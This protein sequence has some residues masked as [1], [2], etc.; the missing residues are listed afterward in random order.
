MSVWKLEFTVQFKEAGGV[1][2]YVDTQGIV[3]VAG[4]ETGAR[5]TASLYDGLVGERWWWRDPAITSCVEIID[6]GLGFVVMAN[7]PTG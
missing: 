1:S 2:V 6:E 3:V 5:L 4:N 7:E